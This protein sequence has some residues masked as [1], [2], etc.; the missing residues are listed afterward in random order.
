MTNRKSTTPDL[1]GILGIEI[2]KLEEQIICLTKQKDAF[3]VAL[4]YAEEGEIDR[5]VLPV[6]NNAVPQ[7]DVVLDITEKS[8]FAR[9]P[10]LDSYPII[11][12]DNVSDIQLKAWLE[13]TPYFK[14]FT[15]LE[16]GL[17]E[18]LSTLKRKKKS[19]KSAETDYVTTTSTDLCRALYPKEIFD[20]CYYSTQENTKL[21]KDILRVTKS[22][23]KSMYLQGKIEMPYSGHYLYKQKK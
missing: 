23:L 16:E 18:Y 21:T 15:T 11:P 3:C 2:K 8:E 22:V 1:L 19:S 17:N 6:P 7:P 12:K 13:T 5:I 20:Y 14:S 9:S 4:A 10:K